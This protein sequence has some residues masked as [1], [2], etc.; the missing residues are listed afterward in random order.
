MGKPTAGKKR[1]SDEAPTIDPDD[2]DLPE[3]MPI[4]SIDPIIDLLPSPPKP[5]KVA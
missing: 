4:V 3:D 2:I 1:K 5:R